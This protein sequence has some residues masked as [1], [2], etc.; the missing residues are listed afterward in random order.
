MKKFLIILVVVFV[1]VMSVYPVSAL[2]DSRPVTALNVSC[3]KG[4]V[5][6][7][8]TA[9]TGV[10]ATAVLL[11]DPNSNLMMMDTCEVRSSGA[12][13][14][15]MNAGLTRAGTYT[16]KASDYE[17]GAFTEKTFSLYS[18]TYYLNGG[19]NNVTNPSVYSSTESVSLLAP[20]RSGY[21]FSGWYTESTFTTKAT[22]WSAGETGDKNLYAKWRKISYVSDP[23]PTVT[24]LP[25]ATPAPTVSPTQTPGILQ[26]PVIKISENDVTT[27]I[28]HEI[29]RAV[30]D[31]G[32]L[33]Q[34]IE[35]ILHGISTGQIKPGEA[36]IELP[37]VELPPGTTMG[38]I[39][40]DTELAQIIAENGI[41]VRTR[42]DN[43][44]ID[45][46]AAVLA[47]AARVTGSSSVRIVSG[48][49]ENMDGADNGLFRLS[50][51]EQGQLIGLPYSFALELLMADGSVQNLTDF[52]GTVSI[53]IKLTE[54][55]LA[56]IENPDNLKMVY[57]NPQTS[58]TEV[59]KSVFDREA[60]TLTF[61][62]SHFSVFQL[63]EV[64]EAV[65]DKPINLWW[66]LWVVLGLA[67]VGALVVTYFTVRKRRL[68]IE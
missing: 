53:T 68:N 47:Q 13:S 64:G 49:E 17:G 54:E 11:F 15:T 58:E 22:G 32:A 10:K 5:S 66:I 19:T 42:I 9:A 27:L 37:E 26:G 38:S 62:T 24:P 25:T 36:V 51:G 67:I 61:F 63:M 28:D 20:T 35:Q 34:A 65:F 46:P 39:E 55:E 6:Y 31:D 44:I 1:L 45:I 56:A 3:T 33:Q 12:F 2:A 18:I 21:R 57:V 29:V 23:E 8:G 50:A 7:N 40:F 4:Q 41:S 30:V 43:A 14:G 60:G 48:R 59:L 16:V 52:D